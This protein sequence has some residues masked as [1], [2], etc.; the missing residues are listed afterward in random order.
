MATLAETWFALPGMDVRGASG[1]LIVGPVKVQRPDLDF[2]WKI[3][4]HAIL[5]MGTRPGIDALTDCVEDFFHMSR[6]RGQKPAS[7]NTSQ[8]SNCC[9]HLFEYVILG[10]AYMHA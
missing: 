10:E 1:R 7:R 2:N 5:W 9:P 3:V 6:C 8:S 4:G